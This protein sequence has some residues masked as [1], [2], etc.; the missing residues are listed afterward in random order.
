MVQEFNLTPI[1]VDRVQNSGIITDQIIDYISTSKYVIADLTGE[2][3]NTYYEAG[4]AHALNKETILT[5][6]RG[7]KIHFDLSS[8][9]FI[10]LETEADLRKQLRDRFSNLTSNN[11]K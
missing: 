4:F 9:R 10:Q 11:D 8:H 2:R 6:K 3:P 5:I 1:K 7:E